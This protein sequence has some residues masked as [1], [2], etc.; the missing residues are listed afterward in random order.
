MEGGLCFEIPLVLLKKKDPGVGAET[1][2]C[3]GASASM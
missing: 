3:S 2:I 1:V